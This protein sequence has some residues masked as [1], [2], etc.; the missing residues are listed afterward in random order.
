MIEIGMRELSSDQKD[1]LRA[2]DTAELA[3]ELA[4]EEYDLL[5]RPDE[6]EWYDCRHPRSNAKTE[7]KSTI[8]EIGDKY[9]AAGRFRLRLDQLRS[10]LS[11]D[12]SGVAWI[13][14]VVFDYDAG[15]IRLRRAKPSTVSGWVRERGG[16]NEAGHQEF[17]KQHK[18]PITEVF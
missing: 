3:E 9:P 2:G 14:F 15:V 18:L 5:H 6:A 17:E 8:A 4:A 11:S 12:A 10:L 1:M 16:W 7:T 13:V